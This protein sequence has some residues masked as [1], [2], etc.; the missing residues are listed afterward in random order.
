MPMPKDGWSSPEARASEIEGRARIT[1][2]KN[3][4]RAA[5]AAE[6]C[7][8]RL[9]IEERAGLSP[10]EQRERIAKAMSWDTGRESSYRPA[11]PWQAS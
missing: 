6:A 8:V 4:Q 10:E 9:A 3:A 7:R 11:Y 5:E 2:R 1:A